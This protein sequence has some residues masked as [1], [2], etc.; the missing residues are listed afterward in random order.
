MMI[1]VRLMS[2]ALISR[3][4]LAHNMRLL[5]RAAGAGVGLWPAVKA[6][7]YGHGALLVSDALAELGFVSQCVARVSEAAELLQGDGLKRHKLAR[8]LVLGGLLP[9]DAASFVSLPK[10]VEPVVSSSLPLEALARAAAVRGYPVGVHVKVDTGMSRQGALPEELAPLLQAIA[11]GAP[12]LTLRGVMSHFAASDSADQTVTLS[13]LDRFH[14]ALSGISLPSG[15]VRFIAN[16][17][18]ILAHRNSALDVARP[19]IAIYGLSPGEGVNASE[20]RPILELQATTTLLKWVPAG[21]GVSYGHHYVTT[22][23]KTLLATLSVGY[24]DGISRAH[25]NRMRVLLNGVS[26]PQLGRV[27]MDQVNRKR[28]LPFKK[29]Y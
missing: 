28:V 10:E 1:L 27:T 18:G 13:Q 22:K 9:D 3:S 17:G 11:D 14:K 26:C 8:V 15:V 29:K 12:H 23:P 19:G 5:Q 25:S 20:L 7:A 16:S 2:V 24:G 6:N 21:T 4:K